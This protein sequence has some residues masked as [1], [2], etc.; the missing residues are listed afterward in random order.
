MNIVRRVFQWVT[1]LLICNGAFLW[2]TDAPLWIK[3][4]G[5]ILPASFY[6]WIAVAPLRVKDAPFSLKQLG[7]GC[8]LVLLSA[9]GAMLQTGLSLVIGLGGLYAFPTPVWIV[10]SVVALVLLALLLADG[11]IRVFAAS[12]QMTVAHRVTL[13]LVWWIPLANFVCF[14]VIYAAARREFKFRL[15]KHR[16]NQ[17]RKSQRIC[18]TKY[19]LLLVHGIFFRDWK[20]VNYW[21]RIPKELERNGATIHYGK[22]QSSSS[23]EQSAG[24][25]RDRILQLVEETGCEKVNIIAHSKGGLD[26]RYAV[27]LLGMQRYVASLTTIGT[28]HR[29]CSFAREAIDRIPENLVGTLSKQYNKI[30]TR[31][32]DDK[33]DFFSGAAELTDTKCAEL[34]KA[35][36]D[37]EGVLYQSVGSRMKSAGSAMFPLN[38]GYGIVKLL[39][40]DNDGLV[41][42]K[43]MPWGAFTMLE[44]AG[45]KGISHGD[46]ID[47]TRKDIPGF[48]VCEFYV[49]LV[50]GLKDKGL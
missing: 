37:R 36:P 6:F 14:A 23:V 31:L 3:L 21:G 29:G 8:E 5:T 11:M 20:L 19:P 38:V 24:E 1:L 9:V 13:I 32:G 2:N 27:G 49:G 46:M 12:G 34:N 33:P 44:P 41:A 16:L 35:I 40:G 47:L 30:F 22:Q 15:E 26:A 10:N 7:C 17:A 39:E 48:D 4:T 28:P 18:A 25:L 45:K 43:S 50:R 42:V